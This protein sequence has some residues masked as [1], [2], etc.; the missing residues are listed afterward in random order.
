MK[1]WEDLELE[2]GSSSYFSM[3]QASVNALLDH[4][5][6]DGRSLQLFRRI[7]HLFLSQL[8]R[9]LEVFSPCLHLRNELILLGERTIWLLLFNY[10]WWPI[11]PALVVRTP[12]SSASLEPDF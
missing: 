9:L 12:P 11:N 4:Y 3:R 10:T 5:A 2:I 7:P 1:D 8:V 6:R